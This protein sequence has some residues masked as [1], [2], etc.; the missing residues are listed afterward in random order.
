MKIDI[1]VL[2][3][4]SSI[5]LHPGRAVI[6]LKRIDTHSTIFK[7]SQG[8]INLIHSL[9]QFHKILSDIEIQGEPLS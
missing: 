1:I 7:M 2:S 9:P 8:R 6:F 5:L 4:T 3:V